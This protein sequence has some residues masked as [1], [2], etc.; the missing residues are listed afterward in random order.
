MTRMV[1][2]AAVVLVLAACPEPERPA[3]SRQ[4]GYV[5]AIA[6]TGDL[7]FNQDGIAAEDADLFLV[8]SAR[9]GPDGSVWV[10]DFNNHRLRRIDEDG[11]I[12][13]VAGNGFHALADVTVRAPESPLE[14]PIDLDF[15]AD[16]RVVIA[17][18]HDPR[19]LAIDENG[20]FEVLAGIGEEG[21]IGDEGDGGDA[22]GAMFI[23]LDGIAIA[24]DDTIYVSD[25]KANRVRM[26][27]DGIV[28]TVA[29]NGEQGYSGDGGPGP[30]AALR[31]PSALELDAAGNLYIADTLNHVVRRLA[32]NG[33]IT[34]VVGSGT[35]G[36]A[37]DGGDA[38]AASL[39]QPYGLALDGESLYIADRGNFRIRRVERGVIATFAGTGTRGDAGDGGPRS[40]ADFAYLARISIDGDGLLVADQSNSRVRRISF[41]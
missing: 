23:Q 26:I 18:Y 38:L 17:S 41:E 35:Q 13:T 11:V 2:T 30:A 12:A 32:T 4:P 24:A 19:V 29:G 22:L 27:R 9:R 37:G 8:S 34:S 40:A 5:C 36:F 6:G 14:N 39:D 20:Q 21:M 33:T 25:S 7:G 28:D 16:G 15:L 1:R 31:W 3:C 10:I